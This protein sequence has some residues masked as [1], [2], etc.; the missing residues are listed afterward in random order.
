[1]GIAVVDGSRAEIASFNFGAG[2]G[3]MRPAAGATSSAKMRSSRFMASELL[4]P[5]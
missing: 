3:D 5:R 2:G 4:L 1:M